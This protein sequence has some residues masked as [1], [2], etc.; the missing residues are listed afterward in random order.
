MYG[1]V[2]A[3]GGARGAYEVGAWRAISDL[4][5]EIGAICGTSIGSIN[6]AAF[7]QG[8]ADK[9]ERLWRDISAADVVDMSNMNG[10]KM[11]SLKNIKAVLEEFKKNK[12]MSMQPL[13]DILRDIID[14]EKLLKSPVD[15]G[16]MTYSL[17]D[18][19]EA[20]MFKN[21]IPKGKLIDYLMASACMPGIK[22][23]VIDEKSFIDG[24]VTDNKPIGML[25]ERGYRD[26]IAV[27]VGGF[28]IVKPI[29]NSGIN[30]IEVR[31]EAPELGVMQFDRER[32]ARSI[33]SG[34]ID[35]KRA[36]GQLCGKKYAFRTADYIRTRKHL[37]EELLDGL[38]IAADMLDID[39]LREYTA[40]SL[41]RKVCDKYK[42][43][44]A[45]Y[46][47]I[48]IETLIGKKEK[49]KTVLLVKA[50][51]MNM[52]GEADILCGRLIGNM[53]KDFTHAINAMAYFL[54]KAE[55]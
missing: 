53:F 50:V 14:E 25:I 26:I 33:K 43:A 6:G 20:A 11:V 28:G 17:T 31:C 7:A 41:S 40:E 1:L 34:Y 35:T 24:C 38:E 22:T 32:I 13:E 54:E 2:L 12:G 48:N 30:L 19:S 36:F 42:E 15:F 3:G 51:Q 21:D 52:S 9:A 18:F 46:G 10:A 4:G 37:S 5:L 27:D 45:E 44:L 55:I 16:L 8:D 49:N 29:K 47:D 23:K 39:K